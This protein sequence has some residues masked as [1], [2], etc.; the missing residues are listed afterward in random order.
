MDEKIIVGSLQYSPIYKSHCCALGKQ[1]EKQGYSVVYLF[2]HEYKWMLSEEI[3]EKTI[4]VGKSKSIKSAII[5]GFD[6]RNILKLKN[7]LLGTNPDYIYM[8]NYHP[9]LN[10]YIAKLAK[11]YGCNFIQ[12]V[13]EPYVENKSIYQGFKQYWLCIFELMQEKLIMNADTAI[14]SSEISSNLFSKR[15]KKYIGKKSIIPLMYEDLGD[16]NKNIK[17]RK[18]ITFIGPPVPAKGP[19]T[20]LKIVQYSE[21]H[22]LDYKFLLISR[23]KINDPI[24]HKWKNLK[25]HYKDKIS[26]EEIGEFM[27]QSL[28][29]ITPYKIAT[30]S[31][32]VLTS[33]MHGT[34]AISTNVGGL[35]EVVH[36]LKSGYLV[37]KKSSV[38]EWVKGINYIANNHSKISKYCRDYFVKNYSEQNWPKYFDDVLK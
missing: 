12:H 32:V 7:I 5:D 27:K 10:Y 18:Y 37:D 19:E 35:P 14:V 17:F 15:Y 6:I 25:I 36:H 23:S 33:Y 20:F 8:Y 1:C 13:Q 21:E 29:T 11:K 4:F 38:E 16:V 30:Q 24:Y 28:M 31:S 26:D 34:P 3:K 2:S 22:N 9:F